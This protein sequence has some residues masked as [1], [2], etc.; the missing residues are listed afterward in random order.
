M[1]RNVTE[2]GKDHKQ[3]LLAKEGC[4]HTFRICQISSFST[5]KCVARTRLNIT[6]QYEIDCFLCIVCCV[7]NNICRAKNASSKDFYRFCFSKGVCVFM[8]LIVCL[9]LCAPNLCF[10]LCLSNN[11]INL[12][13]EIWVCNCVSNFVS[14]LDYI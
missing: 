9:K 13:V 6:L 3:F 2:K 11:V 1:T 4:N 5:T 14:L 12:F 8:C 7:G 10:K